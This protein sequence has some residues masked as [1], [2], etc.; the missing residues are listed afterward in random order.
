MTRWAQDAHAERNSEEAKAA[1]RA[2]AELRVKELAAKLT[3]QLKAKGA[4]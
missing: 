4:F 1:R 3:A 2:V